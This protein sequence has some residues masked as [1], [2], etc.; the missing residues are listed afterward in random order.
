[1]LAVGMQ[2]MIE[3]L[4]RSLQE[5]LPPERM[6]ILAR[7]TPEMIQIAKYAD[8]VLRQAQDFSRTCYLNDK[9]YIFTLAFPVVDSE[10]PGDLWVANIHEAT[11]DS[12]SDFTDGGDA[13]DYVAWPDEH[14]LYIVVPYSAWKDPAS[15]IRQ[16]AHEEGFPV[17]RPEG[18]VFRPP[19]IVRALR[20]DVGQPVGW[21]PEPPRV[22]V[23]EHLRRNI[24]K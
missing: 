3:A 18:M 24:T 11:P 22:S 8:V 13:T 15:D 17:D 16:E 1:M 6:L 12:M 23:W 14:G 10:E 2:K 20:F 19:Q 7:S 9:R 21:A 5:N 4:L